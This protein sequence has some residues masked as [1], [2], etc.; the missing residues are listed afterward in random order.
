MVLECGPLSCG[1]NGRYHDTRN[2]V[3]IGNLMIKSTEA[4]IGN[5]VG[6]GSRG[7]EQNGSRKPGEGTEWEP[8]ARG[9]NRMGAGREF[10]KD[11]TLESSVSQSLVGSCTPFS[12]I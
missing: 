6:A 8:E 11:L 3:Y 2:I 1:E 7:R 9:E 4:R 10:R 5:R 12:W